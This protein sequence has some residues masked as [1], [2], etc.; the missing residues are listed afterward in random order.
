MPVTYP[1]QLT[2]VC[3]ADNFTKESFSATKMKN[4]NGI[5]FAMRHE[6]AWIYCQNVRVNML[7]SAT[8]LDD[9]RFP[10]SH[11]YPLI[12]LHWETR[13]CSTSASTL[14]SSLSQYVQCTV[15]RK[16][17][18]TKKPVQGQQNHVLREPKYNSDVVPNVIILHI[19]FWV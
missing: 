14:L 8:V 5:V 13:L 12:V 9:S 2:H 10:L 19:Q 1:K 18:V 6:N 15:E 11:C 7:L 3:R 17:G 4:T 16:H